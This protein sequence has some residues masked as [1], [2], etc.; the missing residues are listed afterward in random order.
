MRVLTAFGLSDWRNIQ[1]ESFLLYMLIIPWGMVAVAQLL[2]PP[3]R[4]WALE[5]YVFDIV[6]LYP[7]FLSVFF[8]IEM[9]MIFGLLYGLLLLDERDDHTLT[10][11]M[12]TPVSIGSYATYRMFVV[13]LLSFTYVM[14]T[15]LASGLMREVNAMQLV[16]VALVASIMGPMIMLLLAAFARNK[17]EGLALLK[18]VGILLVGTMAAFFV[19][20]E[21]QIAFGILPS[22]WVA[23]AY[24]VLAE[25]GQ[26]WVYL[27]V[28]TAYFSGL[29]LLLLNVFL[30]RIRR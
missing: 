18:G 28:G 11:V 19:T 10:A 26:P 29:V 30:K 22:Y 27:L 9:P 20:S 6:A 2:V 14:L 15:A 17:V 23:K 13:W 12:V 25:G 21:W 8:I 24:W 3:L 5:A 7:L 4:D 16:P 1:R